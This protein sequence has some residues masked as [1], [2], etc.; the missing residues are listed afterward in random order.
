MRQDTAYIEG[1]RAKLTQWT[2]E[3]GDRIKRLEELGVKVDYEKVAREYEAALKRQQGWLAV[4]RS[5]TEGGTGRTI[6]LSRRACAVLT[7]WLSRFPSAGP[8]AYLLPA[9]KIGFTGN[10]RRSDLYAV[11]TSRPIGSW[12]KAWRDAL[13][14][15]GLH[16][17]W[18]D[19]RHT[20]VSRL[21]ENPTV[22]EQ[23]IRT[24]AG[25]S[26]NRCSRATRIS[27]VRRSKRQSRRSRRESPGHSRRG[28]RGGRGGL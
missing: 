15:A 22:S 3:I 12:K 5:K 8:D 27:E 24:M 28:P 25:T 13:K 20:F 2:Q 7:L 19:A 14:A 17:R 4:S 21:A 10:S 26:R 6:P 1:A 23:T 16:Y 18:H 11:D 9:H